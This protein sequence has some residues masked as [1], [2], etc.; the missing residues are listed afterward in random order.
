MFDA[1]DRHDNVHVIDWYTA[2]AG[3]DE[4]FYGDGTISPRRRAEPT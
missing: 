3:H 2:S 1:V 4:Y